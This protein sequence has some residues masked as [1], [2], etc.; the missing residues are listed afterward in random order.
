MPLAEEF[1][2]ILP[3]FANLEDRSTATQIRFATSPDDSDLRILLA[4]QPDMGRTATTAT[5]AA[6]SGSYD[7]GLLI[8]LGIAASLSGDLK[9]G[10]VCY[11]GDLIDALDNAKYRDGPSGTIDIALS[12][13]PY[14]TPREIS[15]PIQL[16]RL[17]PQTKPDYEAWQV[18][19][20]ASGLVLVPG[21]YPGQGGEVEAIDRPKALKALIAC[22]AVSASAGYNAKLKGLDRRILALETES[23]GLFSFA[24]PVGI[25][26]LVIRGICDYADGN[27]AEFEKATGGRART[28]AA[29]NAAS[30]LQLQLRSS[31]FTA[32][33]QRL[34]DKA[35]GTQQ[36]LALAVPLQEDPIATALEE[37]AVEIEGRLRDLSP[38]YSLRDRGYRLPVPRIR[39]LETAS[40]LDGPPRLGEPIEVRDALRAGRA[41]LLSLPREYP[42]ETTAWVIARDILDATL[43]NAQPMPIVVDASRLQRPRRGLESQFS[44]AIR[45]LK[46]SSLVRFVII[47]DNFSFASKS[48]ADFLYEQMEQFPDANFVI[49]TKEGT[50]LITESDFSSRVG[51]TINRVCDVSFSEMTFFLQKKHALSRSQAEVIASRLKETL[52]NFNLSLHPSYV[53]GIPMDVLT[54]LLDANRRAELLQLAVAGY[55]SFVVSGD[56]TQIRLSRTTREEFLTSLIYAIR[57]DKK[58]FDEASLIEFTASV[59]EKF[60]YGIKPIEFINGFIDHGILHFENGSVKFTLPFIEAYLLAKSLLLHPK[61]AVA[62][63]DA[64]QAEIDF[65]TFSIYAELGPAQEVIDFISNTLDGSLSEFEAVKE[66]EN[67]LWSNILAPR[68]LTDKSHISKLRKQISDATRDV[69]SD[70]DITQ[71][72]QQMLD[73]IDEIREVAANSKSNGRKGS[74]AKVRDSRSDRAFAAFTLSAILVGAGAERLI[75]DDKRHFAQRIVRLTCLM[76]DE[77]TRENAGINFAE[78]KERVM[79]NPNISA[80]VKKGIGATDDKAAKEALEALVDL[81]EYIKLAEPFAWLT[82]T[83]CENAREKVLA[84]SLKNITPKKGLDS[85]IHGLWLADIDPSRGKAPLLAAIKKMPTAFFLRMSMSTHLASR[86]FWNHSR[87]EDQLTLLEL[88][89][90]AVQRIGRK[91]DPKRIE[92]ALID[93]KADD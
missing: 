11:T 18:E 20:L 24:G 50:N 74:A 68:V 2:A 5:A 58:L 72:K 29:Q 52:N 93:Q 86:A 92:A 66:S 4:Q 61:E 6:L 56:N 42:D 12:S 47:V 48:R 73:A 37:I 59:S 1:E 77:W 40:E 81:I 39:P 67:I 16:S 84:Q 26:V 83:L 91:S 46:D 44:D 17:D 89:D 80:A 41:L 32:V 21:E 30:F 90:E 88:A 76:A 70:K 64:T 3:L 14:D 87:R 33:L 34:R 71:E 69:I 25:P 49:I 85:I 13:V 15:T 45:K 35:N 53:A 63:F 51:G 43:S 27:K 23:G 8:C 57:I 60:D 54:S 75:A 9:I 65:N 19:R 55:L 22:G 36:R 79:A 28:L 31:R 7:F 62:Y 10:D 78:I 38:G 82:Y